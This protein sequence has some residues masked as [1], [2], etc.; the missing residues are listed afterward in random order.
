MRSL[1]C[2]IHRITFCISIFAIDLGRIQIQC[3]MVYD[4]APEGEDEIYRN[5]LKQSEDIIPLA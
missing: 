5:L 1:L 4:I 3:N 2:Y